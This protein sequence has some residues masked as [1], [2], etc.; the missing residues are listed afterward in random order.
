MGKSK[1]E[2]APWE[3]AGK[4]TVKPVSKAKPPAVFIMTLQAFG[5]DTVLKFDTQA[6]L[7]V[8]K[9]TV[10]LRS[11]RNVP[12]TVESCGKEYT[13]IPGLGVIISDL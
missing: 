12:S 11:A 2:S 7:D 13:I 5:A 3:E 6:K 10:T 1:K 8:A 4:A 9:K